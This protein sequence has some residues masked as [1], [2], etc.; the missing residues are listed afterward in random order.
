MTVLWLTALFLVLLFLGIILYLLIRSADPM[1]T[2]LKALIGL[3]G[4]SIGG[5]ALPTVR[6]PVA[7]NI[8]LGNVLNL[9][10][11]QLSIVFQGSPPANGWP[12][13]FLT[14]ALLTGLCMIIIGNRNTT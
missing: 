8:N 11:Q 9:N 6:G 14:I 2:A 13:E 4:A 3:L 1:A 10:S 7:L 12:I 5:Y